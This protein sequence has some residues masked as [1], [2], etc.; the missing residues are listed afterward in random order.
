MSRDAL[1]TAKGNPD[2]TA[3]GAAEDVTNAERGPRQQG[4]DSSAAP[5]TQTLTGKQEHCVF[6]F[7]FYP[8]I[9]QCSG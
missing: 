2:G 6:T 4:L 9:M 7:L 5:P 1:N 8:Y 3:V